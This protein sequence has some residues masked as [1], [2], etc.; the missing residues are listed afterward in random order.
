MN[1]FDNCIYNVQPKRLQ[2][3]YP[4]MTIMSAIWEYS[5]IRAVGEENGCQTQKESC[6]QSQ[7]TLEADIIVIL[8]ELYAR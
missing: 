4:I 6:I 7:I 5:K 1:D 2:K 8:L 3:G